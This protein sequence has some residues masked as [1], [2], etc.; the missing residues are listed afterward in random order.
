MH[1]DGSCLSNKGDE[2]MRSPAAIV[3]ALLLFLIILPNCSGVREHLASSVF[4]EV[5]TNKDGMLSSEEFSQDIKKRAFAVIDK[6]G[7]GVITWDELVAVDK[8]PQAKELLR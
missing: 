8:R 6:N 1:C 3:Y 4:Y 7:D 2:L 5:D